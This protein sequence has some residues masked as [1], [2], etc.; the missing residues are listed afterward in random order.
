MK[1]LKNF[2]FDTSK[3]GLKAVLIDWQEL[4]LNVVWSS[5]KGVIS[6]VVWE[7]VNEILKSGS[8]S[9]ASVINFLEDLREGGILK[10]VEVSG[11]GGYHWVYSPA[12]DE[13]GFKKYVATQ[14]L[15]ALMKSFPQETEQ[16]LKQYS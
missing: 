15:E 11:K 6:R 16:I 4:A 12:M 8:I 2:E 13:A 5:P 7:K 1:H 9:R 3:T 14:V 10:G